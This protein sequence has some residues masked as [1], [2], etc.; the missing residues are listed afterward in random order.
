MVSFV[1]APWLNKKTSA[2]E[3]DINKTYEL[4]QNYPNPFNPSTEITF[5]I[6]NNGNVH[7]KVYNSI[8]KEV[9]TLVN[10]YKES[11]IYSITFNASLLPDGVYYYTISVNQY[12]STKKM[13]LLK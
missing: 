9:A 11:G 4:Y 13:I 1:C 8:G 12:S 2:F 7:L 5:Q 6:P 10:E 3:E